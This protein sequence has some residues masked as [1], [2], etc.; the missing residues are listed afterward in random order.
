MFLLIVPLL[1]CERID[2]CTM[3][4]HAPLKLGGKGFSK[5]QCGWKHAM[6]AFLLFRYRVTGEELHQLSCQQLHIQVKG[7]QGRRE[8]GSKLDIVTAQHSQ[9][10][11]NCD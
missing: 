5:N 2:T 3:E 9:L 1:A 11:G 4:Y 6:H 10:L 8:L 7:G